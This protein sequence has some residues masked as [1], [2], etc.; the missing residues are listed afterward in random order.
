MGDC[1]VDSLP[2]NEGLGGNEEKPPSDDGKLIRD[3]CPKYLAMGM[4]LTEYWDGDAEWVKYTREAYRLRRER[5]NEEHWIQGMYV[6][7][8]I[9]RTAPL[10]NGFVKNPKA[11]PYPDKPYVLFDDAPKERPK[12]EEDAK[13]LENQAFIRSWVAKVNRLK[14]DKKDG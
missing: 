1:Q 11:E 2:I 12:S 4:S 7:D 5:E 10:L 6:Y 9:I 13:E 3:C 14:G 8:A